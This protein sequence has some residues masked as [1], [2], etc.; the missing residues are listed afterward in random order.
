MQRSRL[1]GRW[2]GYP[3]RVKY[4]LPDENLQAR[5]PLYVMAVFLAGISALLRQPLLFIAALLV[6][7]LAFLPELWYR[8]GLRALIVRREP[9]TARVM[10]GDTVEIPL[11]VEN[12][13]PL[14]LPWV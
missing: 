1:G 3:R 5:R 4:V 10:F 12:R 6:L 11:V 14:P 8:F 9:A 13:K 7:A 2:F